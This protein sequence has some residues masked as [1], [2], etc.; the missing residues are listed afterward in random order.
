[1]DGGI[2]FVMTA[3]DDGGDGNGTSVTAAATCNNGNDNNVSHAM[4]ATAAAMG[5]R[6]RHGLRE[7]GDRR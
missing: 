6:R 5:E 1:V 7:D 3:F 4:K 2:F